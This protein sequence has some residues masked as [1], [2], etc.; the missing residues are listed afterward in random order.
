[1]RG[2]RPTRLTGPFRLTFTLIVMGGITLLSGC[3]PG[4][5]SSTSGQP[6]D[7]GVT[8]SRCPRGWEASPPEQAGT[9]QPDPSKMVST[10][11]GDRMSVIPSTVVLSKQTHVEPVPFRRDRQ[12]SGHRFRALFGHDRR[13]ALPD[14][15]RLGR[16][17]LRL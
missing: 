14:R 4:S 3:D 5:S 7:V 11:A 15:Q 13:E 1:M 17:R 6:A 9:G 16:G 8:E 10:I 12:G 2:S